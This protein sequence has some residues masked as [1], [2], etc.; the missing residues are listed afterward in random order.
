MEVGETYIS[1]WAGGWW[2]FK[3]LQTISKSGKVKGLLIVDG[4]RKAKKVYIGRNT[5]Y[6]GM[7]FLPASAKEAEEVSHLF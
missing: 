3:P 7:G 1:R 4:G 2:Y 6:E 5:N